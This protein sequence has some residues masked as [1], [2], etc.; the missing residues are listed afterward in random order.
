LLGNDNVRASTLEQ[1]ISYNEFLDFDVKYLQYP[2]S[3]M[4]SQERIIPAPLEDDLTAKI[5]QTAIDAFKAIRGRGT[6]RIDFLV[7]A[8]SGEYWL[9]EINTHFEI[10]ADRSR[11]DRF[12]WYFVSNIIDDCG[13]ELQRQGWVKCVGF[14]IAKSRFSDAAELLSFFHDVGIREGQ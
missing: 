4:K 7:N 8:E 12:P 5:Q 6:A 2:G 13:V 10:L 11:T 1:P 3:G 14:Q 9:N